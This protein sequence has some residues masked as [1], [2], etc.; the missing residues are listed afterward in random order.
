MSSSRDAG[1]HADQA[2]K[3]MDTPCPKSPNKKHKW[4]KV[5]VGWNKCKH[6]KE[7]IYWK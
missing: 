1:Y 6:C 2:S 3:T 5:Q 7:N 4:E